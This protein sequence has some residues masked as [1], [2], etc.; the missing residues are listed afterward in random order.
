M[1]SWLR[2]TVLRSLIR[3]LPD[4]WHAV[5]MRAQADY[6]ALDSAQRERLRQNLRQ[7]IRPKAA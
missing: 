2:R 3:V 7:L 6:D 5:G 1:F 4:R